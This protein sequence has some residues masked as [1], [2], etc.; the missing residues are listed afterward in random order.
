MLIMMIGFGNGLSDGARE[1]M[2]GMGNNTVYLWSQRTSEPYGGHNPGREIRF[3][4]K[5]Y[6]AIVNTI[7]GIDVIAPR[8]QLAGYRGTTTI[9]A[10]ERSANFQVIADYPDLAKVRSFVFTAGRF[11]NPNDMAEHRKVAVIGKRVWQ[12]LF[13]EAGSNSNTNTALGKYINV[14]GVPFQVVG[15]FR[16]KRRGDMGEGDESTVH[17]PF[18]T[19]LQ[20]F[21]GT[22]EIGWFAIRAK[23][24]VAASEMENQ[25]RTLLK[26]RHK[27]APTDA[28]ALGSFNAQKEF[29]KISRLFRLIDG[30]IWIVG[31]MTLLAGVVGVSNIMLIAI[32]ERTQE[33]GLRKALGATPFSIVGLIVREALLLT[34]TAGV[35]GIVVGVACLRMLG[36]LLS[37][38]DMLAAPTVSLGV[39]VF[40]FFILLVCG[41]VAGIIPAGSAA[42]IQPIA[43]LRAE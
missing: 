5:D 23:D 27:I 13:P 20:A 32:R 30:L 21:G 16:S 38:A 10:A 39:V 43:A 41:V 7:D 6:E 42:R 14:Q 29:S 40:A 34:V 31:L 2:S 28:Q 36:K 4:T 19:Y 1:S 26:T 22:G 9:T 24:G 12:E 37:D 25:V 35:A 8:T 17:I 18:A 33:I 11:F 3:D 15:V